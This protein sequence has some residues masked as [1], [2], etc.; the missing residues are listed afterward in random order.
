MKD[1]VSQLAEVLTLGRQKKDKANLLQ[2]CPVSGRNLS[3]RSLLQQSQDD[4]WRR[5]PI[6]G[7]RRSMTSGKKVV[8]TIMAY[9]ASGCDGTIHHR[10][11]VYLLWPTL[12]DSSLS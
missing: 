3:L 2:G 5:K 8:V 9:I 4:C 6:D 7:G 11:F 1:A 12:D 10:S